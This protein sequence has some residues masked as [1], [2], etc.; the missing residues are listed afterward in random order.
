MGQGSLDREMS[1]SSVQ[2]QWEQGSRAR[3]PVGVVLLSIAAASLF[4]WWQLIRLA[5]WLLS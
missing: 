1:Y 2:T 4:L 5:I 3:L